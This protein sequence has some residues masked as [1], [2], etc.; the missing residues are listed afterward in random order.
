MQKIK[1]LFNKKKGD[2]TFKRAGPG[3]RL[4]DNSAS[5]QQPTSSGVG[6]VL[7]TGQAQKTHQSQNPSQ[8]KRQGGPDENVAKATLA[9]FETKPNSTK[10]TSANKSTLYDIMAEEKQKFEKEL[11]MKEDMEAKRRLQ[12]QQEQQQAKQMENPF[13]EFED[14]QRFTCQTLDLTDPVPF[15][16]ILRQIKSSIYDNFTDD[17]VLRSAMILFN[18]NRSVDNGPSSNSSPNVQLQNCLDILLKIVSNLLLAENDEQL[19]KFK[20]VRRSK[21]EQKVLSL[22]G[23][24][25]FMFAIGFTIDDKDCDWLVYADVD[26]DDG[27]KAK[28]TYL[29]DLISN[30]QIIHIELDRQVKL[31]DQSRPEEATNESESDVRLTSADVKEYYSN[32]ERT[33][34]IEEM[35]I[36]KETKA[37]LLVSNSNLSNFRSVFTKLRFKFELAGEMQLIEAIF[38]SKETLADVQKWFIE[39][40]GNALDG[41]CVQFKQGLS[42]LTN[43]QDTLETLKLSPASTLLAIVV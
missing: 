22:D 23:A 14:A 6:R 34:Q 17:P 9:R 8:P 40:F 29:K 15:K 33:R 41:K 24:L 2:L 27:R 36:S 28:M 3:Y 35:L 43:E 16:D 12:Q 19:E 39:H 20:R 26:D 38:Y 18:C 10:A 5:Q 42:L 32:I 21:I 13:K 37:K 25:D 30:P 1:D 7:G 31:I 4:T 11:K